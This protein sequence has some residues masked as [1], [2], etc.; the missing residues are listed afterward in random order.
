M[1]HEANMTHHQLARA[2]KKW[3]AMVETKYQELKIEEK[4]P[5]KKKELDKRI[6]DL[7]R[8]IHWNTRQMGLFLYRT[9]QNA[10]PAS[11]MSVQAFATKFRETSVTDAIEKRIKNQ[12]DKTETELTVD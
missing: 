12:T 7:R 5:S 10:F 11:Q 2:H 4:D 6:Q 9:S 3:K 1:N 8:E